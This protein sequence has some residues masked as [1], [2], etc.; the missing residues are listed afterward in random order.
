MFSVMRGLAMLRKEIQLHSQPGLDQEAA[1]AVADAL[2]CSA[3]LFKSVAATGKPPH[4]RPPS[5]LE[6]AIDTI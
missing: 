1:A 6:I 5:S 3:C 2:E 4:A